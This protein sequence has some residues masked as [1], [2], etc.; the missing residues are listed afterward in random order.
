[1]YMLTVNIKDEGRVVT[2]QLKS[3]NAVMH[4]KLMDGFSEMKRKSDGHYINLLHR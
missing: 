3:E 2:V 4:S 1:M